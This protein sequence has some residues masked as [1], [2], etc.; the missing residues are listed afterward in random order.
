V[1]ELRE[2]FVTVMSLC[3]HYKVNDDMAFYPRDATLALYYSYGPV[4]VSVCLSVCVCVR[5][6]SV[7][8]GNR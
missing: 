6:K 4:S 7:F 1:D 2:M 8:Y 3:F 5:Q